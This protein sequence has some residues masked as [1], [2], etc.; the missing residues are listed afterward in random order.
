MATIPVRIKRKEIWTAIKVDPSKEKWYVAAGKGMG[1]CLVQAAE[2][3]AY[4][5]TDKATFLAME[6]KAGLKILLGESKDMRNVYSMIAVNP[7][8]NPGV[9]VDGANAFIAWMQSEKATKMIEKYGADKY[10]EPLFLLGE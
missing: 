5:L 3:K 9:N 8:K 10:G 1:A 4:C 7:Q 6:D 2:M